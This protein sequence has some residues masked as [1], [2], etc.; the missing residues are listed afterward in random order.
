VDLGRAILSK[1]FKWGM[2]ALP[3][4]AL[5]AISS[6]SVHA[7]ET[8]CAGTK[9]NLLTPEAGESADVCAGARFAET[10]LGACGIAPKKGYDVRVS[11][12]VE[13]TSGSRLYGK[14]VPSQNLVTLVTLAASRTLV[15]SIRDD[16]KMRVYKLVPARDLYRAFAAHEIAHAITVQHLTVQPS[17]ALYEYIGAVVQIAALPEDIRTAYLQPFDGQAATAETAFNDVLAL[18]EPALFGASA[19]LHFN[20]PGNG[21]AFLKR[22]LTEPNVFPQMDIVRGNTPAPDASL[23]AIEHGLRAPPSAAR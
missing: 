16:D 5:V 4:L 13:S 10:F 20:A 11:S 17:V 18:M 22:L 2:R 7:A 12:V 6:V 9:L 21:C 1:L 23:A 19:Y 15:A 3:G 8:F 14:F